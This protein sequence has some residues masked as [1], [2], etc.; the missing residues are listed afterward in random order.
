M[1]RYE[2]SWRKGGMLEMKKGWMKRAGWRAF[3]LSACAFGGWSAQ[4]FAARIDPQ[5]LEQLRGTVGMLLEDV[6]EFYHV[7]LLIESFMVFMLLALIV[8][9]LVGYIKLRKEVREL[10]RRVCGE[11]DFAAEPPEDIDSPF[12]PMPEPES[13]PEPEPEPEPEPMP[14]P[15][16]EPES[17]PIVRFMEAY[18]EA[19]DIEDPT[20]Q[21]ARFASLLAEFSSKRFT[22]TNP[23]DRKT[24]PNA[25]P[26]F[27]TRDEGDFWA[28]EKGDGSDDYYVIPDPTLPYSEERH[29]FCGM[30]EAFAS[31]YQE[32]KTYTHMEVEAPARFS[33]MGSLWAPQR[34][35]KI[36]LSR[37]QDA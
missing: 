35:G 9:G 2:S 8:V 22:C 32:G 1:Q 5:E 10:R 33:L 19:N 25:P 30:K 34:P 12:E 18:S 4:A 17:P 24:N 37:E 21:K 31:N 15:E 26:T 16:R 6:E 3:V 28:V 27:E 7:T 23:E 20:L 11:D 13:M 29:R 14:E 36:M